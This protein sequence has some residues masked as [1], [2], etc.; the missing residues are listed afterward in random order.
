MEIKCRAWNP[1]EHKTMNHTKWLE[2]EYCKDPVSAADYAINL[3]ETALKIDGYN[4]DVK[5]TITISLN[6]YRLLVSDAQRKA[7][8]EGR[9][10]AWDLARRIVTCGPDC[11]TG[12]EVLDSVFGSC[13]ASSIFGT[14]AD[15]AL[16]KDK[17]Y[18]EEKKTL[19]VGD[20]VE[21]GVFRGYII[22]ILSS[23]E[24]R[25]LT[26]IYDTFTVSCKNCKKTG[27]HSDEIEK[28]MT[29]F[30]KGEC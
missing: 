21:F 25:V 11:Y 30:E 8:E 9:E 6:E 18:Q 2:P 29:S 14:S 7:K 10:E 16:A 4:P 12:I 28:A 23:D 13:N 5:T 3:A 24:V 27:R 15:E 1:S 26:K 19:H 22:K 20:E 17:K